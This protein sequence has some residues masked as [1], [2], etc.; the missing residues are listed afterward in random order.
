M[1]FL[2]LYL[3]LFQYQVACTC[4]PASVQYACADDPGPP[5]PAKTDTPPALPPR[6]PTSILAATNRRNNGKLDFILLEID[7]VFH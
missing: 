4:K 1:K 6:P 5:P 2:K 3:K 7:A